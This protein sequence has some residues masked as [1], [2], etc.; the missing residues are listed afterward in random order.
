MNRRKAV[1]GLLVFAGGLTFLPS[2]LYGNA[3]T[4]ATLYKNFTLTYLQHDGLAAIVSAII[5][6][7]NT[8]GAK[9]LG[10]HLWILKMLDDCYDQRTRDTFFSGLEKIDYKAANLAEVLLQVDSKENKLGADAQTFFRLT[11]KLTIKGY[12]NSEYVMTK[13]LVYELVP[14]RWHGKVP[15]KS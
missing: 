9:E 15:V 8:P 11:K 14:G 3:A 12:M 13:L 2:M 6:A 10:V 4:Y 7:T 5:P 1:K